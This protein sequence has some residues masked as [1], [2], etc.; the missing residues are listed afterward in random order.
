MAR[1]DYDPLTLPNADTNRIDTDANQ[2]QRIQS[3]LIGDCEIT[4]TGNGGEAP[5]VSF[6]FKDMQGRNLRGRTQVL[7]SGH[8]AAWGAVAGA[9]VFTAAAETGLLIHALT[10]SRVGYYLTD[11]DGLLEIEVSGADDDYFLRVDAG[12]GAVFESGAVTID[13]GE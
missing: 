4:V 2:Q 9:D 5:V 11:D 7:L 1:Y 3:R 12:G 10:A 6:Q 13:D 8:T